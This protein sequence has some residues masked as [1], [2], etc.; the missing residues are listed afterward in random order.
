MRQGAFLATGFLVG[1]AI[2]VLFLGRYR[3]EHGSAGGISTV[4]VIDRMTGKVQMLVGARSIEVSR[5]QPIQPTVTPWPYLPMASPCDI[6]AMLPDSD[7]PD[8]QKTA[9]SWQAAGCD[10]GEFV[11]T[12]DEWLAKRSATPAPSA[13][14]RIER[15][16][17]KK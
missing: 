13:G 2:C 14:S 11:R 5:S 10:Y 16:P 7:E 4:Y 3:T 1:A 15:R 12:R 9:K 8:W 6:I 17:A